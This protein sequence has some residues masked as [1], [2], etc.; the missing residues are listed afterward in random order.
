MEKKIENGYI[1][2]LTNPSFPDYVKIGY[3]D[4]VN[5]RLKQL[6]RSECIPFAFRLYAYY[7]VNQRLTDMKLHQMIDKLNPNLRSIEEF[8]GKTR[9]REF[10]NMAASDAY[11]ILETIAQINCLEENLVLVEPTAKELKDEE[12]AEE[13][14]TKRSPK[15]YPKMDWLIQQGI[16]NI[17]DE[18]FVINHP[19]E[20]AIVVDSDHVKYKEETMSFNQF[21]CKVTGWKSIQ[22]YAW[23]KTNNSTKTLDELRKEKMLELGII[24]N[25]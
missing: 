13:I 12:Q 4:D 25:K 21:G 3:A 24:D 18:L 1:Y 10:Y 5:Q 9:K 16:V 15:Q 14:R 22:I 23:T 6:N 8:D 2:I 7:K 20:K 17:G 11:A 19:E